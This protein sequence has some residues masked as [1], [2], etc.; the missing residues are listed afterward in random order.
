MVYTVVFSDT[1]R[2]RPTAFDGQRALEYYSGCLLSSF[3]YNNMLT[4]G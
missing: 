4:F 1:P 3:T 2:R